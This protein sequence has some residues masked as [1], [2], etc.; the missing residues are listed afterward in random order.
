MNT[1]LPAAAYPATDLRHAVRIQ[2]LALAALGAL[3]AC[4][5]SDVVGGNTKQVADVQ[6]PADGFLPQ[7]DLLAHN[8]GTLWALTYLQPG[9]DFRAYNAIY[10]HLPLTAH[11][12][13]TLTAGKRC[14]KKQALLF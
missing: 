4:S 5:K 1:H 8:D 9:I 3:S 14:N 11:L 10:M 13:C 7:P 12:D 6:V 2:L